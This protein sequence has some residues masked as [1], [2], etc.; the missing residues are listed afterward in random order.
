VGRGIATRAADAA[1]GL[2]FTVPGIDVVEI[3]HDIANPTSG[4]V[5]EKLG[6]TN[7]GDFDAKPLSP[8]EAGVER[9]W[10]LTRAAWAARA[11]SQRP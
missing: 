9:R 1:A 7:L 11:G 10:Q 6:F 5:P 2:A 3:H 4:R 8:G